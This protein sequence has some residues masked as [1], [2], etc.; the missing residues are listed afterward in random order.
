MCQS[1]SLGHIEHLPHSWKKRSLGS[2]LTI[3]WHPLLLLQQLGQ[4]LQPLGEGDPVHVHDKR[5]HQL[6]V[7]MAQVAHNQ[8]QVDVAAQLLRFELGQ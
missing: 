1:I 6:P 5:V 7:A 3:N 8:P 4:F 2:N